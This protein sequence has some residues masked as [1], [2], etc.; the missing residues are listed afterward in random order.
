MRTWQWRSPHRPTVAIMARTTGCK[1][2]V[3][4]CWTP[5]CIGLVHKVI[6]R[7]TGTA[8]RIPPL[9]LFLLISV[10]VLLVGDS[11]SR[12]STSCRPHAVLMYHWERQRIFYCKGMWSTSNTKT[13]HCLPIRT[14]SFFHQFCT[15]LII[16]FL[17]RR[18]L[19]FRNISQPDSGNLR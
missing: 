17:R 18:R 7:Y 1:S 3:H 11:Q 2:S 8:A 5:R 13:R 12:T 14:N 19:P 16:I 9:W 15:P 6:F 4:V 10:I